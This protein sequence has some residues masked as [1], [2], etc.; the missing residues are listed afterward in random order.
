L[1]GQGTLLGG[2]VVTI[3]AATAALRAGRDPGFAWVALALA[4]AGVALVFMA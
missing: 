1:L 3:G 2:V 4:T